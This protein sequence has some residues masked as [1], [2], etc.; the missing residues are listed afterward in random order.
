MSWS[1]HG[2][3]WQSRDI[4]MLQLWWSRHDH[5]ALCLLTYTV[6]TRLCHGSLWHSLQ[7]SQRCCTALPCSKSLVQ[8]C[9]W[10]FDA[11][12]QR[13]ACKC[14]HRRWS[15]RMNVNDTSLRDSYGVPFTCCIICE[16]ITSRVVLTIHFPVAPALV[17]MHVRLNFTRSAVPVART[18][19]PS[20]VNRNEWRLV[21]C[22]AVSFSSF[23]DAIF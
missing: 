8:R 5:D 4:V 22:Q 11:R 14:F 18:P 12:C 7:T 6:V 15:A 23:Q 2:S 19:S 20:Q 10:Y 16:G 9:F 13:V 1:Y 21:C 17:H 3:L